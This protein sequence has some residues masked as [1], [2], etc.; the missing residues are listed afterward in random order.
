MSG[1][2]GSDG[3]E[4]PGSRDALELVLAPVIEADPGPGDEVDDGARDTDL[5]GWECA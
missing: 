4:L 3:E 1:V 5:V 2:S